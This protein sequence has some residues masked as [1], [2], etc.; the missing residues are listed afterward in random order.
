MV[1]SPA[2]SQPKPGKD[3]VPETRF[4]KWFISSHIWVK[5]VL[6][7]AIEDMKRL[8]GARIPPGQ[9]ILDAGCGIGLAFPLLEEYFRPAKMIGIDVDTTDLA[10]A[11]S[12]R[13][14][15]STELELI[16]CNAKAIPLPDASIDVVYC[17]QLIHHV[18]AQHEVL[19]ELRRVLKPG[20]IL[21]SSESCKNF[22]DVWWV[23]L[24]F[25]H[26]DMLQKQAEEYVSLMRTAGFYV[27]DED[28]YKYT[29]WWSR[30][31]YGLLQKWK[32][33]SWSPGFTE[34]ITIAQKP[35]S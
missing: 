32:L 33:S 22:L 26:P 12:T 11:Q 15:L 27:A 10:K 34:V 24:F 25:R 8:A 3:W 1:T 6:R 35:S 30:V 20:G 28:V 9:V 31:D 23:K 19:A 29:P 4:G 16:R 7:V 18:L 2:P 21:L 14:N 5:Y 17:H 13:A